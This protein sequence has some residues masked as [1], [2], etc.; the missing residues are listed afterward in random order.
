MDTVDHEI[1]MEVGTVKERGYDHAC[2]L[3]VDTLGDVCSVALLGPCGKIVT[4]SASATR[5]A[6]QVHRLVDDVFAHHDESPS[7]IQELVVNIGPG[8]LT[9]VKIGIATCVGYAMVDNLGMLTLNHLEILAMQSYLSSQDR[10]KRSKICYAVCEDARMSE[11]YYAMYMVSSEKVDC[12]QAPCVLARNAIPSAASDPNVQRIGTAWSKLGASD[13][14]SGE[15]HSQHA[16]LDVSI[17]KAYA[18]L[19]LYRM[20]KA[21]QTLRMRSVLEIQPLYL[22]EAVR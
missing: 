6:N 9:G 2:V 15:I 18:M 17:T 1:G 14:Q 13:L 8:S 20:H 5:H 16:F 22:R 3:A 21:N 10:T 19:R 4:A 7:S 12:V 11:Y